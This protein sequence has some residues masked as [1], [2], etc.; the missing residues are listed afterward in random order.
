MCATCN[1]LRSLLI[2]RGMSPALAMT[3]GSALEPVEDAAVDAAK[4]AVK[5]TKRKVSK[6]AREYGKAYKSL[7]RKHPRA[8][9]R[10]LVK[11]AHAVAKK[12][13]KKK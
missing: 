8:Q 11:K 3:I 1:V 6:Y 4:G 5:K 7:K 10:T 13:A 2:D 12:T 9:H